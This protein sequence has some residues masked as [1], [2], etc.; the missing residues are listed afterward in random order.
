MSSRM[1]NNTESSFA[2]VLLEHNVVAATAITDAQEQANNTGIAFMRALSDKGAQV[3]QIVAA[4]AT[5]QYKLPF[6]DVRSHNFETE[7]ISLVN[8]EELRKNVMVP[9]VRKNGTLYLAI[10]DP[11]DQR[12]HEQIRFRTRLNIETVIGNAEHILVALDQATG[13]QR[14]VIQGMLS[15]ET[16]K[17]DGRET[18]ATA[19]AAIDVSVSNKD[20]APIVRFIN[21]VITDAIQRGASDLHFE[22]YEL[23]YR[24]RFRMDGVLQ[25]VVSPPTSYRDQLSA[26]IKVMAQL[27]IT[28]R[29]VPQDGRIKLKIGNRVIDFRVSTLPTLW[30]EKIVMRVLDGSAAKLDIDILGF[31]PEQKAAIVEAIAKPQGMILVTGP[32]GSGKT[33][34]LYTALGM[35]NKP[36]HNISTAEDP[37]EINLPGIN[38]VPVNPKTGLTFASALRAFLRQDPDIIMVGEIRD[39]ETASIAIKAAQTGH[40]VLS[41]LHTNSAP[42][43]LTRLVNMGIETFNLAATVHLILAQRLARRLC[44]HCKEEDTSIPLDRL[45]YMGFTPAQAREAKLYAPIGCDQ[46]NKGYKGRVGIYEVM[47]ISEQMGRLIMDNAN[48]IDLADQAQNEGINN[49]RQSAIIKVLAG[50]TSI[51]EL[52]RVTSD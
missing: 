36:T 30:G 49:L 32:T 34:T 1:S 43:T 3:C 51:D 29:R 52:L 37:V 27:D 33:V 41:T 7:I 2:S 14:D 13:V 12:V 48:S 25:E 46:C 24:V 38:Q 19:I 45:L 17:D 31:E 8:L 15:K 42:E 47:P 22:P 20:D 9:L 44:P 16:P 40:L 21:G 39:L 23:N 4:F 26:R 18:S 11:T 50:M 10:A 35:L 6:I 5:Q 28:E